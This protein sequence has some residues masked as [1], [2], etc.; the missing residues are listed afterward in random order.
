MSRKLYISWKPSPESHLW[1]PI[2]GDRINNLREQ[3]LKLNEEKL[4]LLYM[5][6]ITQDEGEKGF[7][8]FSLEYPG[9]SMANIIYSGQAEGSKKELL[10]TLILCLQ[11]ISGIQEKKELV[12]AFLSSVGKVNELAAARLKHFIT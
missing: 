2:S 8:H 11:L 4:L 10:V 3:Y 6:Q 1:G 9:D 7:I 5:R 12:L